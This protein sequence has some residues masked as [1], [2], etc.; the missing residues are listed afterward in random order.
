MIA[1]TLRYTGFLGAFAGIYVSVDEGIAALFGKERTARWRAFVAGALAGP[2]LLLTGPKT[3]HHSLAIYILLRGLTLLVRCGNKPDAPPLVRRLLTPT[4]W[5]HGDTALMCACTSQIG[6]SW[7]CKPQTL[8]ATFVHFLNHHGGKELWFYRAA[9][10]LS[11]RNWRGDPPGPLES[12][13]GTEHEHTI[14]THP[15]EWAHEGETCSYAAAKFFPG[16]Y[17][18][19][20]P[21]YLPVYVLPAILVHR[22]ALF[23]KDG[24][25]I[26]A[27]VLKG[28]LRS[29]AFLGL[30]CT[31]CW[32]GA[33]VGFQATQSASPPVIAASCWTGG[34]ATLVEK[35]SRR[36]ELAIY[37]ASRALESFALCLVEWGFVRKRDVPKRIDVLMFSAAAA[38]IMHCYSDGRGRHRDVFRSKYLNVL[39][40]VFGNTG[41][42]EGKISHRPS[43][44]DLL[45]QVPPM[46][47]A[48]VWRQRAHS[49]GGSLVSGL[50]VLAGKDGIGSAESP[51]AGDGDHAG[52]MMH[53]VSGSLDLEVGSLAGEG[54]W[55]SS[56]DENYR[57]SQPATSEGS[58]SD[59]TDNSF[60]FNRLL[61]GPII[62]HRPHSP[63]EVQSSDEATPTFGGPRSS[64]SSRSWQQHRPQLVFSSAP[65]QSHLQNE[66]IDE[67]HEDVQDSP[68]ASAAQQS[69]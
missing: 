53:F 43:T 32:R 10:E 5:R 54:Q 56:L 36:M 16:A 26:W 18:R 47:D 51:R 2:S 1:D 41:V 22:R 6:Y 7:I 42:E 23:E 46:V 3:R 60:T 59:H 63:L 48:A 17:L 30:Y 25:A 35:K 52:S 4:R 19:A 33:C 67:G 20:L 11:E 31:L 39:D 12:L 44:Q 62:T 28:A 49:M 8:P 64:Y 68:F 50:E 69:P 29:S 14:A 24:A 55:R 57:E 66:R 13:K 34:L 15:C 27:K 37:C 61:Q 9:R 38:A 40:F 58:R 45:A 21:V 65:Q